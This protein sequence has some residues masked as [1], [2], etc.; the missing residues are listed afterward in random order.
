M[1]PSSSAPALKY[2]RRRWRRNSR[3]RRASTRRWRGIYAQCAQ[4]GL[5]EVVITVTRLQ[6]VADAAE[7]DI[8]AAAPTDAVGDGS[9][10]WCARGDGGGCS[11]G[12]RG[13]RRCRG[14]DGKWDG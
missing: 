5:I 12:R 3:T 8:G 14:G 9:C 13:R 1:H 7:D 4:W 6:D 2:P 10:A 11:A